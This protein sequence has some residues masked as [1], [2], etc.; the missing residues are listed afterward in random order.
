MLFP[1]LIWNSVK[2]DSIFGEPRCVCVR[3][4]KGVG[5][6]TIYARLIVWITEYVP[7]R[8]CFERKQ[9]SLQVKIHNKEFFYDDQR[10]LEC[11]SS[12]TNSVRLCVFA[13]ASTKPATVENLSQL[14]LGTLNSPRITTSA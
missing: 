5:N 14:L 8:W 13:K 3:L 10:G 2:F 4:F 6:V 12:L 11:G 7:L 1:R 9:T